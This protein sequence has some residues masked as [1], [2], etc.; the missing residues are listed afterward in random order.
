MSFQVDKGSPWA[1]AYS[2]LVALLSVPSTAS[3]ALVTWA[4][5]EGAGGDERLFRARGLLVVAIYE[6]FWLAGK[7][8]VAMLDLMSKDETRA[9]L[10]ISILE[11]KIYTLLSKGP[12]PCGYVATGY[13]CDLRFLFSSESLDARIDTIDLA[14][15]RSAFINALAVVLGV[16][17]AQN[18]YHMAGECTRLCFQM[19]SLFHEVVLLQLSSPRCL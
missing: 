12:M 3:K 19:S 7:A 14:H 2:D 8:C 13:T 16:S 4:S 9:V 1:S 10:K 11:A 17:P 15:E 18:Y 6:R 5:A